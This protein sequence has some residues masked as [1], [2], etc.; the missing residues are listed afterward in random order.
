M[1]KGMNAISKKLLLISTFLLLF[2]STG[3]CISPNKYYAALTAIVSPTGSGTVYVDGDNSVSAGDTCTNVKYNNNYRTYDWNIRD[4]VDATVNFTATAT[5]NTGYS[6]TKWEKD[7]SQVSASSTY[8][9]DYAVSKTESTNSDTH[10][11][12]YTITAVFTP[13][14]YTISF[15]ANGGS[16]TNPSN[17]PYTIE[18]TDKTLPACPYTKADYT[19][20][21]WKPHSNVGNW[22]KSELFEAMTSVPTGKWGN[23]TLDAQWKEIEYVDITITVTGLEAGESTVFNV[24]KGGSVIFTVAVSA[25]SPTVTIK[26]QE[27]GDYTVT[28]AGWNW[29]YTL[30]PSTALTKTISID[31][32]NFSFTA[33]K[34]S[35]AKK[36][37]EQIN[38]NWHT[39]SL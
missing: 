23:V 39:P 25:E 6:F 9:A 17:I 26:S 22:S 15:S 12:T 24:S 30:S 2:S 5:P 29:T 34:N 33:S 19:F 20:A 3:Y 36:H 18:S 10:A 21:G 38:V 27:V 7:G 31:D 4:Y 1:L 37:D 35:S 14:S 32:H 8:S 16:G 28:P 13:I 11:A